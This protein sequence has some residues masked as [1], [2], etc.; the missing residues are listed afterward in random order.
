MSRNTQVMLLVCLVL[1]LGYWGYQWKFSDDGGPRLVLISSSGTV[2]RTDAAGVAQSTEVGAQ[3]EVHDTLR[4]GEDGL[5]LLQAGERSQLSLSATS[6]MRVVSAGIGGVRVE[7]E[8]G[9]VTARVRPG[10]P[11]LG[12]TNR[13]RAVNARDADFTIVV[14]PE[15]AMGIEAERGDLGLQGFGAVR[16]LAEGK[17]IRALPGREPVSAPVSSALLLEVDWPK[18]AVT[19]SA[20]VTIRGRTDPYASVVF[21]DGTRV[22]A[23]ADG[24][25]RAKVPLSEG[26]NNLNVRVRDLMGRESDTKRTVTR[27]STAPSVESSEVLW[28]R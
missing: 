12:I 18:S 24:K 14:D 17:R 26:S 13:G 3:I 6:T 5:I 9:R 16:E 1:V 11:P 7:L 8:N 27:D 22:R 4:T 10:S 15:G 20:E 19:R 23:G 2:E 25:F 28:G 21:S